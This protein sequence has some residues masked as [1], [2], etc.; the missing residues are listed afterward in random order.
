ME[1]V[2]YSPELAPAVTSLYNEVVVRLVPQCFPVESERL[3]G[4]LP[5]AED[6]TGDEFLH[7]QAAF[8]AL[9]GSQGCGSVHVGVGPTN[10][11]EQEQHGHVRFLCYRPGERE[12]GQSLLECAESHLRN[13]GAKDAIAFWHYHRYP[14]YY[15]ESA[16]LSDR[17]GHISALLGM[18]GY[19]R[20]RGEVMMEMPDYIPAEPTPPQI[21]VELVGDPEP[22]PGRFPNLDLKVLWKGKEAGICEGISCAEY[23][24]SEELHEW[25]LPGWLGI[26]KEIQ[27]KGVGRYLLQTALCRMHQLG[28]RHAAIST[29]WHNYRAALFYTNLGY[30]VVDWTYAFNRSLEER[31]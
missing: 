2:P 6:Q 3:A 19:T 21:P 20:L 13:L 1:I 22:G 25:W 5:G 24:S 4:A 9:R 10:R 17:L 16:C 31:G 7:S 14:F 27:G 26:G 15:R 28:Y 12:T 11:S 29:D 30:H 18:N 23:G 8:V